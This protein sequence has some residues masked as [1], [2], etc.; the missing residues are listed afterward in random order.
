[1][2]VYSTPVLRSMTPETV[3]IRRVSKFPLQRSL[4]TK[5]PSKAGFITPIWLLR[6]FK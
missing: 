6:I 5:P 4:W 3:I 1:M 2:V